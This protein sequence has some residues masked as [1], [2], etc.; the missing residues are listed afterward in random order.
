[1]AKYDKGKKRIIYNSYE[2]YIKIQAGRSFRHKP[3]TL[4]RANKSCLKPVKFLKKRIN[5]SCKIIDVGCRNGLFL[6]LLKYHGYKN[7]FGSDLVGRNVEGCIKNEYNVK[8]CDC[9]D[10]RN[11]YDDAFFH[12][13]TCIHT[14]EHVIDP[15]KAIKEFHRILKKQGRMLLIIPLQKTAGHVK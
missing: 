1:M 9:Q 13:V 4:E 15:R 6:G 8:L 12:V 11:V 7:V 3:W 14:L 10:M 5:K 2:E